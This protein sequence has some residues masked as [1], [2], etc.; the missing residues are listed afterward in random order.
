ME[1]Y[2]ETGEFPDIST[3]IKTQFNGIENKYKVLKEK[4]K[5]FEEMVALECNES[6]DFMY[7]FEIGVALNDYGIRMGIPGKLASE[8]MYSYRKRSGV[9]ARVDK[10]MLDEKEKPVLEKISTLGLPQKTVKVLEQEIQFDSTYF[11]SEYVENKAEII[12]EDCAIT[13]EMINSIRKSSGNKFYAIVNILEHFYESSCNAISNLEE[14]LGLSKNKELYEDINDFIEEK[15]EEITA[16]GE[17]FQTLDTNL[18]LEKQYRELRRATRGRW[19]GGGFGVQG[20]VKGAIEAGIMNAVSDTAHVAVNSFADGWSDAKNKEEKNKIIREIYSDMPEKSRDALE[21]IANI[22]IET[23]EEEYP[24][25]IWTLDREKTTKT[26]IDLEHEEEKTKYSIELLKLYPFNKDIYLE[27]MKWIDAQKIKESGLLETAELFGINLVK[28]VQ[29]EIELHFTRVSISQETVKWLNA[30]MEIEDEE[31]EKEKVESQL[32]S[33]LEAIERRDS[34][35]Y[36]EFDSIYRALE[37]ADIKD[38]SIEDKQLAINEIYAREGMKFSDLNA[39]E[40]FTQKQWYEGKID[41]NE[42]DK[43]KLSDIE[44]Y[45]IKFLEESI[46]TDKERFKQE[47]E[48]ANKVTIQDVLGTFKDEDKGYKLI[49]SVDEDNTLIDTTRVKYQIYQKDYSLYAEGEAD[50]IDE[51]ISGADYD[52]IINEDKSI[53]VKFKF[54]EEI[55]TFEKV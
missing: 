52:F 1:K 19:Q 55:G 45:N 27:I 53:T 44:K 51:T 29:E 31:Q 18:N 42:F 4:V 16:A 22:I 20:A 43:D 46:Q 39:V 34:M 26:L 24:D 10:E 30:Y 36:F 25:C 5:K 2:C 37:D 9:E 47:E 23:L 13:D 6:K 49:I 17:T 40:Y 41:E 14:S 54:G 38:W 11:I 33:Y 8:I 3:E 32:K 7:N 28:V 15:I 21:C 35:D 48:E 12:V 50:F